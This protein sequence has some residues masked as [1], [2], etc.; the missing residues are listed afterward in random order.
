M[1]GILGSKYMTSALNELFENAKDLV[2]LKMNKLVRKLCLMI[3]ER[4]F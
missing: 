4:K 2:V 1:F 3:H